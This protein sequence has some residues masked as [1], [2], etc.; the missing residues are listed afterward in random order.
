MNGLEEKLSKARTLLDNKEWMSLKE[1]LRD[2]PAPDIAELL[3]SMDKPARVLLFRGLPRQVS[4]EVFSY[5]NAGDKDALLKDLTD[6]EAR[7]LLAALSPDDRT[8]FLE[9]LPGL[10]T[11]RLLN[12]L[13]P[14]DLMEARHLLGYPEESVGRLM[15][16]DYVAVRPHWTIARALAHI[17]EKGRDS[18][19]V[20]VVYVTDDSWRLI[21]GLELRRFILADLSNTVFQIMDY[22]FASI[23]AF[24]DR[25]KAVELIQRYDLDALPV[26]DSDGVLIGIVTVDD[27]MDVAQEE[28]TEDFHKAAA[29]A[30]LKVSYRESTVWLLFRKRIIWLAVLLGMNLVASGVIAAYEEVLIST[31]ALAFFIP[32]LI[33]TGGNAGAQSATLMVRAH[34]DGRRQARSMVLGTWQGD[35]GSRSLGNQHGYCELGPWHFQGRFRDR[36][37]RG[38]CD[39]IDRSGLEFHRG[40]T[41]FS[42]YK[43]SCRPSGGKQPP[44]YLCCGCRGIDHL[45]CDCNTGSRSLENRQR[46]NK[47]FR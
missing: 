25:E 17:R 16:P 38:D 14:D 40:Y 23:S 45:F 5:L 2:L 42:S 24:E 20:N 36:I 9:E 12:L 37:D 11:Q 19:T 33:A 47:F 28:A 4:S 15:T 22:A 7:G 39:A 6:E 18:E 3:S 13:G 35:D 21:D 30:P 8:E 34:S 46:R 1:F 41:T 27:V 44:Y 32:L 43:D 10:A 26:V 31:I 29:V